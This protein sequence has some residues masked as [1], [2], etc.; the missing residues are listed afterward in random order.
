[1]QIHAA[2]RFVALSLLA[3]SVVACGSS[4]SGDETGQDT[5]SSGT[6]PDPSSS[7]APTT[8]PD[9]SESSAP[10]TTVAVTESSS[11]SDTSEGSTGSDSGSTGASA[12]SSSSGETGVDPLECD[13]WMQDCS[14]DRKCVPFAS[15]GGETYDGTQCVPES[16][17]TVSLGDECSVEGEITSGV[18]NCRVG[19]ICWNVDEMSGLGG[20]VALCGESEEDP[21]C[22]DPGTSCEVID[23]IFGVCVSP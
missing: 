16:R 1:M 9:P 14:D 17:E 19:A 12:D 20:C 8:E 21:Y 2:P 3:L 22:E 10:E 18:D 23:G 4:P 5:S 7:T 13:P 6:S 11:G 15:D